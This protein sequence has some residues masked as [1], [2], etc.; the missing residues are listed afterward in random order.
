M[1]SAAGRG[2]RTSLAEAGDTADLSSYRLW[3]YSDGRYLVTVSWPDGANRT[4]RRVTRIMGFQGSLGSVNLGDI[5]QTISM[6][7]QTGTL[8]VHSGKQHRYVWFENGELAI[9]NGQ[10]KDGRPLLLE[11][12]ERRGLID[13]STR[14]GLEQRLYD[15]GQPLRDLLLASNIMPQNELDDLCSW[16]IE[17]NVCEIF[18]WEDGDFE[19]IDGD[20][21]PELAAPEIVEAGD[22]RLQTSHV[23]M[24]AMR[25]IDEWEQ[26]RNVIP[27]PDELFVVDNE[28]RANLRNIETDQEILKVLRFLDGRHNLDQISGQVGLPRFDTHAIVANLIIN[29]IT[30]PRSPEEILEDALELRRQGEKAQACH[31]LETALT[32]LDLPE[33]VRPLAELSLELGDAPRAVELYLDLVQRAQDDG[34]F[35][36]ALTDIEIVIE[37]NPDDPDLQLDKAEVL[38][39]LNRTEQASEAFIEAARN[40]LGNRDIKQAIDSCHRAKDL[41]PTA[42]DPHRLLAQAYLLD[43]QSENAVV[44]YKS[45]WHALL[46]HHRPRKSLD[47]LRETLDA[48]CKFPRIKEQI[49]NHASGS[50][51]VK[52]STA[53]RRLVNLLMLLAVIAAG[54]YG[55]IYFKDKIQADSIIK[56]LQEI[57]NALNEPAATI[58]YPAKIAEINRLMS[59]NSS[60][61]VQE[62]GARL[63]EFARITYEAAAA[64]TLQPVLDVIA[65][66]AA[67]S[68]EDLTKAQQELQLFLRSFSDTAVAEE[69]KNLSDQ[70]H[71]V[72]IRRR[73]RDAIEENEELFANRR[74]DEATTNMR[75][76]ID[77]TDLTGTIRA[78]LQALLEEMLRKNS[79]A[80]FHYRTALELIIQERYDDAMDELRV[81]MDSEGDH[82]KEEARKK[83]IE[84]ENKVMEIL[85]TRI[86]EFA[87]RGDAEHTFAKIAELEKLS[88]IAT[89]PQVQQ[90]LD[91]VQLPFTMTVDHHGVGIAV[92]YRPD[93]QAPTTSTHRAPE[94]TTGPWRLKIHYQANESVQVTASRPGFTDK[95]TLVTAE[96]KRLTGDIT[97][98]RGALWQ[99]ALDGRPTTRP[100]TSDK[101][102]LVCTDRNNLVIIDTGLGTMNTVAFGNSVDTITTPP[103]IDDNAGVAY[104]SVSGQIHAVQI[105]SRRKLWSWPPA[106]DLQMPSLGRNG[107]WV[108]DNKNIN[109]KKQLFTG[110]SENDS[111][112]QPTLIH[113]AIDGEG[114]QQMP[115]T[116]LNQPVTGAPLGYSGNELLFVPTAAGIL[117]LDA[118]SGDL[119]SPLTTISRFPLKGEIHARPLPATVHGKPSLLV[120]DQRNA[121]VALDMESVG[122]KEMRSLAMWPLSGSP[123]G[124][125]A[126][127]GTHGTAYIALAGTGAMEAINLKDDDREPLLWRF[128]AEGRVGELLGQPAIGDRGIYITDSLGMLYCVG[129]DGSERWKVDLGSAASTAVLARNGKIYLGT[130]AGDLL[131]FEEG[132]D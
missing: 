64:T 59:K 102:I 39:E 28:G 77:R 117:A 104:V 49:L 47:L 58:D 48:D 26:I 1:P 18:E 11:M 89:S 13:Q 17:E 2:L 126:Y 29:N 85:I 7:R 21:V 16:C 60:P 45:L 132:S 65:D 25:R 19:F 121:I 76:L 10:A 115:P 42:P 83:L 107:V 71:N 122:D 61:K 119:R 131:C 9:C 114:Y 68:D 54:G 82:F 30:R 72:I 124:Q 101:L 112:R 125:P 129:R 3:K 78:D 40:Y 116:P 6:N 22:I 46:A 105:G 66:P 127:D 106:E 90:A 100:I 73:I 95:R 94:G 52:T 41:C 123:L 92:T 74:Y 57:Q 53:I 32:R 80:E 62:T 14:D 81:A 55:Y 93:S 5:F 109:G 36:Q 99:R 91:R 84:L 111:V 33:I 37:I 96:D 8:V 113:L 86:D 128:P 50:E 79:S 44:E 87:V 31:L 108:Q 4:K 88:K 38:I 98:N 20:P 43:N 120:A 24:E 51:A 23:V 69:H 130:T 56:D 63:H 34:D 15:S 70:L 67:H 97:L 27:S 75:S 103:F 35:D 118:T 110:T 12:M